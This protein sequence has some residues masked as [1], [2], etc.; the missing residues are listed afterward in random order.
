MAIILWSCVGLNLYAFAIHVRARRQIARDRYVE[1]LQLQSVA[2]HLQHL[3]DE[4]G[5]PDLADE[6]E[7]FHA[8]SVTAAILAGKHDKAIRSFMRMMNE[9]D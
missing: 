1:S 5:R 3:A 9:T 7:T 6:A 2:N 4:L 8:A